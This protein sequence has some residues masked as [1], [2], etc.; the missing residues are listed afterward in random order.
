MWNAYPVAAERWGHRQ[1]QEQ[2]QELRQRLGTDPRLV[3]SAHVL[4]A[5]RTELADLIRQEAAANPALEAID[6]E[7]APTD[8]EIFRKLELQTPYTGEDEVEAYRSQINNPDEQ[9]SWIDFLAA[10]PSLKEHVLA[11]LLGLVPER[12]APLAHTVVDCLGS[13]GYLEVPPEEIAL[14]A[15]APVED[16]REVVQLL[17]T[18][19]PPGVGAYDLRECLLIQLRDRKDDLGRLAYQMVDRCWRNLRT[20]RFDKVATTLKVDREAVSEALQELS[21]LTPYPGEAFASR[22]RFHRE[23]LPAIAP[24]VIYRRTRNGMTIEVVGAESWCLRLSRWYAEQFRKLR[25]DPNADPEERKLV[26]VFVRRALDLIRS[27]KQRQRT[28]YSISEALL[29][30]QFAFINTGD[31]LLLK[32]LMRKEIAKAC[33]MHLAT[34]SRATSNKMVQLPTGE[35]I[36]FEVFFQHKLRVQKII[37]GMLAAEDPNDPLTDAEI[38]ARLKEM[39]IKLARR[40]VAKYRERIVG[41]GSRRRRMA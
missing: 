17:Q 33:G 34:V 9:S 32:P 11:Q 2:R 41:V 23:A 38:S 31:Y 19:D 36:P 27:V 21:S 1:G 15:D 4:E 24:D 35:T 25:K 20:L 16:V 39:G 40:T 3:L 22:S 13:K 14:E 37:E 5:T 26:E 7:D 6:L 8:E 12:L 29:K 30:A 18:C 10:P 28:L